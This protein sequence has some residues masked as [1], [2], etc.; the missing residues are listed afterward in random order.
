MNNIL[1]ICHG[2]ICRSAMA[3]FIMK[4]MVKARGC[5][6]EFHIESAAVSDEEIGNGIYP[7][8][9][10]CLR[11]HGIPFDPGKTARKVRRGDYD[12]YDLL[13]CM[14]ESNV[15][16]LGVI[17]GGDPDG[18]IRMMMSF[19]DRGGNVADPWY[20][21]DFETTYRYLTEGCMGLLGQLI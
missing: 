15:R 11:M 16:R 14:D 7:P 3:E 18:K 5:E 10:E 12:D 6:D 4:S 13:I 21:G 20:T 2:N 8:A 9:K 19:C 1:F 17:T